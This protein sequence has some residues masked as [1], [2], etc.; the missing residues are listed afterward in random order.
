VPAPTLP[1]QFVFQNHC[2]RHLVLKTWWWCLLM[3]RVAAGTAVWS[4]FWLCGCP[5]DLLLVSSAVCLPGHCHTNLESTI[6]ARDIWCLKLCMVVYEWLNGCWNC[7]LVHSQALGLSICLSVFQWWVSGQHCQTNF[8]S[9][10]TTWDIWSLGIGRIVCWWWHYGL[11]SE[12]APSAGPGAT[13]KC[14][15][16]F[17]ALG[18]CPDSTAKP[19]FTPA[20]LPETSG[21]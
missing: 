10:T 4:I 21:A 8:H 9:S 11:V 13:L 17:P 3:I 14:F 15:W 5:D 12:L 18:A 20:P 1:H 16:S 7:S 19:I 6:T 2:Q